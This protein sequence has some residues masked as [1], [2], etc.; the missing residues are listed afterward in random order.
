MKDGKIGTA[1]TSVLDLGIGMVPFVGS[2]HDAIIL[3]SEDYERFMLGR[4][5]T[6]DERAMRKTMIV[7]G[8]IPGVGMIVK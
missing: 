5:L 2:I 3:S 6:D 1:M 8:A 4:K 7:L